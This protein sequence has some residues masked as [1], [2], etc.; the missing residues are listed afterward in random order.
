MVIGSIGFGDVGVLVF[1][2]VVALVSGDVSG[3]VVIVTIGFG[4]VG[5][6]VVIEVV[7]LVSDCA[8]VVVGDVLVCRSW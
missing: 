2:E 1:M 5:V 8:I 7:A 6:L 3:D 4:D